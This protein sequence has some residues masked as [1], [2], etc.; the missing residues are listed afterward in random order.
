MFRRFVQ[1]GGLFLGLARVDLDQQRWKEALAGFIKS[2]AVM[3]D[4]KDHPNYGTIVNGMAACYEQLNQWTEALQFYREAVELHRTT[5]G[6]QHPSYATS[7]Y[8]LANSYV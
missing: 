3:D 6:D 5:F 4:F 1:Y 7:V 2:K 8:N